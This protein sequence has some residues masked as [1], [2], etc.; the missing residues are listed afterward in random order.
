M[1]VWRPARQMVFTL[2]RLHLSSIR[3]HCERPAAA[4]SE[5]IRSL[6]RSRRYSVEYR[7]SLSRPP[8]SNAKSVPHP[9][10]IEVFEG[11]M[12]EIECPFCP[13]SGDRRGPISVRSRNGFDPHARHYAAYAIPPFRFGMKALSH[14]WGRPALHP[15][16]DGQRSLVLSHKWGSGLRRATRYNSDMKRIGCGTAEAVRHF[17]DRSADR[18]DL[19]DARTT[20]RPLSHF[21]RFITMNTFA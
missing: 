21:T 7:S 2:P 9:G 15:A 3:L 10:T 17:V 5:R 12:R 16:V 19:A 14:K 6:Y 1:C 20:R 11:T 13:T 18:H 8:R 4:L